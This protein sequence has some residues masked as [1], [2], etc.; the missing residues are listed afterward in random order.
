MR[1]FIIAGHGKNT[2]GDFTLNDLAGSAGRIDV[3]LRCISAS[4][5]ISNG[6]R[7]D[8]D[9]YLCLSGDMTRTVRLVGE[10][11][12]YLNPDER[13]TDRKSVV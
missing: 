10:E 3:L 12:K 7:R 9:V 8:T 6:I 5:L 1:T 13:S 2:D 11:L 4:F